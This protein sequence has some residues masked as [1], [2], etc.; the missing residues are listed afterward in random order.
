MSLNVLKSLVLPFLTNMCVGVRCESK[1][2]ILFALY[3]LLGGYAD[4]ILGMN[5]SSSSYEISIFL[6]S[7]SYFENNVFC[8][9]SLVE[10]SASSD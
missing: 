4:K 7:V 3:G 2:P 9:L 5:Y 6:L 10:P 1:A 8:F